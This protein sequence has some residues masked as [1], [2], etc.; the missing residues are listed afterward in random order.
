MRAVS[1]VDAPPELTTLIAVDPGRQWD[2]AGEA[3]AHNA[4]K[5]TLRTS[6]HRLCA[7]CESPVPIGGA[8]EHVHPKSVPECDYRPSE[9]HHYDWANLLLVCG[10]PEHCDG[11]KG[12]N[13]LCGMVLFPDEMDPEVLYFTVD[14]LDGSLI[15]APGLPSEES[16]AAGRALDELRLNDPALKGLR[17]AVIQLIQL[18]LS[19]SED[20]MMARHRAG[21]TRGFATTIDSYF[22]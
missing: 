1:R 12:D 19:E 22:S 18:E 6:Q 8:V 16:A 20:E 10:S 4:I 11:P 17:L 13:D 5:E 14:S 21:C 2:T 7:Y 3:E 9:N 15:V